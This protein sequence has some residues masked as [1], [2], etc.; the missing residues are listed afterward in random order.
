MHGHLL[1]F[2]DFI[3]MCVCVCV[4]VRARA[5][6]CVCVRACVCA[7]VRVCLCVCVCVCACVR[8][9]VRVCVCVMK[10]TGEGLP[11]C[12]YS[13]YSTAPSTPFGTVYVMYVATSIPNSRN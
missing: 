9:C 11:I 6:V 12:Q 10:E 13:E 8:A 1:T 5:Y 2:Q 3:Q 4:C 7:C